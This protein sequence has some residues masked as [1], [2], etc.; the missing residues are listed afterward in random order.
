MSNKISNEM[1]ERV[2]TIVDQCAI[3]GRRGCYTTDRVRETLRESGI[4]Y[5][6]VG[7]AYFDVVEYLENHWG[8]F[9]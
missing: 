6:K 3:N 2:D 8:I 1:K 7:E 4:T 5:G 9:V